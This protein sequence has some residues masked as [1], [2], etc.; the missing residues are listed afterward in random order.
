MAKSRART[1]ADIIVGA[2][3]DIDGN[4]TFDGGSTSE[5]L[6]F[7]D[8]DKANFGDASDLQIYHNGSNSYIDDIGTGALNI[9]S[10]GI[11]LEKA[12]GAEVMA[13]FIADGAATLYHNASVKLGTTSSGV[14]VTG[15][16][17]ATSSIVDNV[18]AKTSSGSI[19][20]K[21]N[22]GSDKMRL[23]DAGNLGIGT[24]SPTEPLT[25]SETSSGNTMQFASF[26]NPVVTAN[27]GVRL[28]L[29][30]TNTTTRGT[31][32]D[33]V[34]ESTANDHSLRFGTSANASAPTERMRIDK[35]GN[36]GGGGNAPQYPLDLRNPSDS[37]QIFRVLFP[38]SS[39]VQIGTSRMGSGNT[40]AVFLEGQ[41]GL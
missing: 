13:S 21:N 31:F 18:T 16:M 30:G 4:L 5:D 37:N 33:A 3:V 17:V 28:W 9:R 12:N 25:V 20:F 2:G 22:S 41:A 7:A 39:T 34:A 40:Q 10:S 29:S 14:S 15:S 26:V 1:L 38:D 36:I 19:T 6:T 27:T 35:S 32:I 24:N 8:G 23:T 11:Y